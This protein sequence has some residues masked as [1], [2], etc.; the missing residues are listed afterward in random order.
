MTSSSPQTFFKNMI[1][2]A[3]MCKYAPGIEEKFCG[4]GKTDHKK[5]IVFARHHFPTAVYQFL[6]SKRI[7]SLLN[8][9]EMESCKKNEISDRLM[10]DC[11]RV[12]RMGALNKQIIPQNQL[13]DDY[14]IQELKC[15][16]AIENHFI[17]A[18]VTTQTEVTDVM[19]EI[20]AALNAETISTL[21]NAASAVEY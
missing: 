20:R 12:R 18:P 2:L 6:G 21:L 9:A 16:E 14:M 5:E 7:T 10:N 8:D 19:N 1:F 17:C 11:N 15:L 3:A 4:N 13:L